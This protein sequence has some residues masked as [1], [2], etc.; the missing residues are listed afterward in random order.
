ME[1]GQEPPDPVSSSRAAV[2]CGGFGFQRTSDSLPCVCQQGLGTT[3]DVYRKKTAKAAP[4][5][6]TASS[7]PTPTQKAGATDVANISSNSNPEPIWWY[8]PIQ[9]RF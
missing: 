7:A 3:T 6:K 8:W 9:F 4:Q 5:A 2:G 1:G